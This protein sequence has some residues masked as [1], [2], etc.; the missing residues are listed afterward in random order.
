MDEIISRCG[1]CALFELYCKEY[2]DENETF[3]EVGRCKKFRQ[4][5]EKFDEEY[6]E[7]CDAL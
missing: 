6:Y 2:I 4:K 3:L 7:D 1:D 5:D